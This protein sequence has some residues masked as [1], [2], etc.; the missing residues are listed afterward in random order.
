MPKYTM[1]DST[2]QLWH[3][4]DDSNFSDFMSTYP[5]AVTVDKIED[6][7]GDSESLSTM[8]VSIP[9]DKTVEEV[10]EMKSGKKTITERRLYPGYVLVQMDMNDDSW[11]L[12]KST[13]KV[14]TFIGGNGQKP[15]AI[16][17]T[18][19][20]IILRR[21]DDSKVNPTQ[22]LKI[23]TLGFFNWDENDFFR[24]SVQNF[25]IN[26]IKFTNTDDFVLRKK[27]FIG[28]GKIDLTYDISITKMLEVTTKYNNQDTENT[29]NLNFNSQ[30]TVESLNDRNTLFDQKISYT[31]KFKENK[32]FLFTGRYINEKIPQNYTINQFF[33]QDLFPS[34]SNA[35][36]VS[37]L[38][39]T[40][41]NLQV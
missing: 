22:K 35:N 41:C 3:D 24:N 1:R 38:S 8:D 40:K 5:D 7:T 16:K 29:S 2:G 12:V 28:F 10:V 20:D 32:V 11:H 17:D 19:V 33:Y 15:T 6:E 4:I 39:E 37:Q 26:G 13:P 18:E 21:M 30:Q 34:N 31:N 25:N 9:E 27:K 14:S 23:K 36:N